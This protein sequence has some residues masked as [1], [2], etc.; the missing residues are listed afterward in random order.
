MQDD[1]VLCKVMH[2]GSCVVQLFMSFM[3]QKY[4][5]MCICC[6]SDV[7]SNIGQYP[8]TKGDAYS[9]L[10][11]G[12]LCRYADDLLPIFKLIV[13]PEHRAKLRLDEQVSSHEYDCHKLL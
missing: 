10:S 2:I 13:L 8:T 5:F 12:P 7:V 1:C 3:Q 11:T 6:L 9:F 4:I